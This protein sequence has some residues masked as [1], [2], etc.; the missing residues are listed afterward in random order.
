MDRAQVNAAIRIW[1]RRSPAPSHGMC[2][3]V[4]LSAYWRAL[5]V[6][7]PDQIAALSEQALRRGLPDLT[8]LPGSVDGRVGGRELLDDWLA[9]TLDLPRQPQALA[10]ARAALLG[11]AVPD[12][13]AV[14]FA[15]P[16]RGDNSAMPCARS[17]GRARSGARSRR[18]AGA[19]DRIVLAAGPAGAAKS[20]GRD[21]SPAE[22][23]PSWP[24]PFDPSAIG[25]TL[26]RSGILSVDEPDHA[27]R[28]GT[29]GQR[30]SD[31]RFQSDGAAAVAAVHDPVFLDLHL[32]LD[33]AHG[34]FHDSVRPRPLGDFPPAGR[35]ARPERAA[36]AHRD[37]DADLQRGFGAGV[38][39]PARHP[40]A[41]WRKPVSSTDFD[42]F[43]L[44][45][46]RDPDVWVEEELRW[47]DMVRALDGKGRIFYRNR[48]ENTSRKSGNLE[49]FCTR[50]GGGYR[51]MIVLDADSIMKGERWSR[52]CG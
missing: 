23:T 8:R 25:H 49:D 3:S 24:H 52:W 40:S 15:P 29:A 30:V 43:I 9:R 51:Y 33:G 17:G 34:V 1:R 26:R 22:K 45:D 37:P 21:S 12:W 19:A 38:R 18:H 13:P 44:S 42:F 41:R 32:V 36:A 28:P 46:T 7:D 16:G 5:G 50:W 27:D 4:G 14:L 31:Q 6:S 11:G 20:G 35:A 47:Q 39:R 10:A 48:P 2:C